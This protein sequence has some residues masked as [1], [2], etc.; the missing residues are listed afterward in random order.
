M[1]VFFNP[2][3]EKAGLIVD[4]V[5][6]TNSK[7]VLSTPLVRAFYFLAISFSFWLKIGIN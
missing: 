3:L 2:V 4:Q 1:E 5:V 6:V 7:E